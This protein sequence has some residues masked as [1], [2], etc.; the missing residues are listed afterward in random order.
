MLPRKR[1]LLADV[2]FVRGS[3]WGGGVGG[4]LYNLCGGAASTVPAYLHFNWQG[5]WW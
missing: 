2:E 1:S 3:D 4:I 5:T